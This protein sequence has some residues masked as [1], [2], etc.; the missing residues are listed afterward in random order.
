MRLP[1]AGMEE[2]EEEEELAQLFQA[3]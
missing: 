1:I 2:E 3:N